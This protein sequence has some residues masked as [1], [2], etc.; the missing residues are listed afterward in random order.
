M[1]SANLKSPDRTQLRHFGLIMAGMIAL[2]FGLGIPWLRDYAAPWWVW[3]IAGAFAIVGLGFPA[4]LAAVYKVWM[5]LGAVLGWINSR[6]ILGV[7]Y[8][9]IILPMGIF[10]RA[11]GKDPMARKLDKAMTTYRKPSQ[12]AA[13]EQLERP[14]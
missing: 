14:F 10:M 1:T 6:I 3:A 12:K 7:V 4:M 8:Y 13:R 2:V 11:F 9:A 5:K